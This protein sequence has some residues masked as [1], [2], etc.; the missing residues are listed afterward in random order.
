[1]ELNT[2]SNIDLLAILQN[3]NILINGVY[4]KD[5]LKK[6]LK[7][8]FYI[9]NLNDSDQPGSHWTVL[10]CINEAYSMYFDAFGFKAPECIE[11]LLHRYDYN[12]KQIQSIDSTSCGFYCIAFI[13]FMH[14]KKNYKKAF[15]TFCK[16][17][18]SDTCMNE[19]VL[20]N[21]LYG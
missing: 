19:I 14:M 2:T 6:P 3:E 21:I 16:L 4:P 7:H 12:K 8:G 10:Y 1:M 5:R 20:H 17:F 15:K 9:I 13:K 11:D 18:N